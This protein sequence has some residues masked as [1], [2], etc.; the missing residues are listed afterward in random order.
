VRPAARLRLVDPFDGRSARAA[1]DAVAEE[2]A[3]E[4]GDDLDRLPL[5]R[6][7]LDGAV[8]RLPGP[9]PVL[10]VGC[11]PGQ[12]GRYLA[13]RGVVVIGVDLAWRMLSLARRDARATSLASADMRRLPL[14]SGSCAGA[15]A[16]YSLQ[17][18]HRSELG[19]ALGELGRVVQPGGIVVLATHLGVGELYSEE[20]LGHRF[21]TV[22]AALHSREELDERLRGQG[23]RV[24]VARER[25]PLAHEH[26]TERLYLIARRSDG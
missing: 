11:G 19:G 22:G 15:V 1:Y 23:F 21:P 7:V 8:E 2:Y 16:F 14:R 4:F 5:D 24:E 12:V 10:D 20:F 26:Q 3:A 6:A 17:H 25:G 9:G 18:V 13:A